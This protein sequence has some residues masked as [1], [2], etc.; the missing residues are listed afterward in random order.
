[1]FDPAANAEVTARLIVAGAVIAKM[2]I[3]M[4]VKDRIM[5]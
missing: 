3:R 1:M 2:L 5:C 4:R